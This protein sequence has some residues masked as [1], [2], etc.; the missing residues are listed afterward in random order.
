M[1]AHPTFHCPICF[2]KTTEDD[3]AHVDVP[4]DL[5]VSVPLSYVVDLQNEIAGLRREIAD[6]HFNTIDHEES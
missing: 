1:P 5:K 2:Q 4:G 3:A 6:L